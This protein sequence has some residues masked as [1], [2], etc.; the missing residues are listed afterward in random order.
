VATNYLTPSGR[1]RIRGR[2]KL[3]NQLIK[4]YQRVIDLAQQLYGQS[5]AFYKTV[6][7]VSK[8]ISYDEIKSRIKNPKNIQ[9][10]KLY[11]IAY[12]ATPGSRNRRFAAIKSARTSTR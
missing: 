11:Y 12:G 3:G 7:Q 9:D 5:A 4:L 8:K 6:N 10:Q 2:R 1:R